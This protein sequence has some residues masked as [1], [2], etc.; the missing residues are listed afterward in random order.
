M[1]QVMVLLATGGKNGDG[2]EASKYVVIAIHGGILLSHAILN[3]L[4][5]SWLSFFGQLA[6]AW[7]ILGTCHHSPSAPSRILLFNARSSDLI[8]LMSY[9]CKSTGVFLLM[10]LIPAVTPDRANAKFVFTHF[11]TDNSDGI[12][13][14]FY[15]F[16]LG[17]LMRQYTITGYDASAH[18]VSYLDLVN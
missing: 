6:A 17:L 11:N 15:I 18:M 1:I 10:I 2:Y 12:R 13:S 5:I 16:T 9:W 14:K 3:G 7:N 8:G 4:S